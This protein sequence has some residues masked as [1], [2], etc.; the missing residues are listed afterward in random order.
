[1]SVDASQP[2]VRFR[3]SAVTL[4]VSLAASV[5]TFLIATHTYMA[6]EAWLASRWVS[7]AV[8]GGTSFDRSGATFFFGLGGSHPAGLRVSSG[9]S[10]FVLALPLFAAAAVAAYFARFEVWRVVGGLAA[11]TGLLVVANQV[12]LVMIAWAASR[13]R[14]EGIFWSHTVAGSGLS[15]LGVVGSLLVFYRIIRGR[16]RRDQE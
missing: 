8:P 7:V 14:Q 3:I 1:M 4:S 9:C 10:A 6:A 12:R 15:L 11:A 5:V 16:G 13:W 2:R